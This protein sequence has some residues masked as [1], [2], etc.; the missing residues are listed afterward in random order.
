MW[1]LTWGISTYHPFAKEESQVFNFM[2]EEH[3][4]LFMVLIGSPADTSTLFQ[5]CPEILGSLYLLL[6]DFIPIRWD[7]QEVANMIVWPDIYAL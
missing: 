5:H 2:C 6:W 1:P 4:Y 3:S 7:E